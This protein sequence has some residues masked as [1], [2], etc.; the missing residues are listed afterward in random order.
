MIVNKIIVRLKTY[1][2]RYKKYCF[3]KKILNYVKKNLKLNSKSP[4]V[5]VWE[6]GGFPEILKIDAIVSIALNLRGFNTLFILCDGFNVACIKK[7]I[8]KKEC[9]LDDN[10]CEKCIKAME[11]QAE[12]FGL[13]CI[14]ASDFIDSNKVEDIL[15]I[16]RDI[17][18]S[19]I[20]NYKS[21]GISIGENALSSMMRYLK[22]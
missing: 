18:I 5:I 6:F 20:R 4:L 8:S 7:E 14:S 12:R 21:D 1:Q 15:K 11:V 22:G 13:R 10:S 9:K 17:N 3:G 2:L 19:D 16:V